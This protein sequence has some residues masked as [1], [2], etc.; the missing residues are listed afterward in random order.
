MQSWTAQTPGS[1]Q[2]IKS[3]FKLAD[4]ARFLFCLLLS[5]GIMSTFGLF[6]RFSSSSGPFNSHLS[7]SSLESSAAK[8]GHAHFQHTLQLDH[9]SLSGFLCHLLVYIVRRVENSTV[10]VVAV[11]IHTFVAV[12]WVVCTLTILTTKLHELQRNRH[13]SDIRSVHLTKQPANTKKIVR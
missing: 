10:R 7:G 1:L 4:T 12:D 11:G 3:E 5:L 2:A 9:L 8:G 13:E 6:S